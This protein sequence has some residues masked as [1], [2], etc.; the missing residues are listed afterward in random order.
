MP[1]TWTQ[2]NTFFTIPIPFLRKME[3]CENEYMFY[4]FGTKNSQEHCILIE[5]GNWK[6]TVR[7]KTTKP[8]SSYGNLIRYKVDKKTF[9]NWRMWHSLH[10]TEVYRDQKIN[11]AYFDLYCFDTE[12]FTEL[13]NLDR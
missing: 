12:F 8:H 13:S 1:S 3:S 9:E 6:K 10:A 5:T 11:L 7:K 2:Q 4:K